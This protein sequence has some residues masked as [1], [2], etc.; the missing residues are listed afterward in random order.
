MNHYHSQRT[1][2]WLRFV[3]L[4]LA[5]LLQ[6][7]SANSEPLEATAETSADL[8]K[9]QPTPRGRVPRTEMVPMRDGALLAT[10]I[11]LPEGQPP[12]PVM[13]IRTPYGRA[14]S[15]DIA[16]DYSAIDLAVVVQDM[17]GRGESTGRDS[18]YRADGDGVLQD[19]YDTF[20]WIREQP[21]AHGAIATFGGS[22]LGIVQY[23]QSTSQPPGLAF[24]HA[25]A[26]TANLYDDIY[27]PGGVFRQKLAVQ[28]LEDQGILWFLEDIKA[29]PY[30][31]DF[32]ALVQAGDHWNRLAAPGLHIGGWFDI[33]TQGT[34]DAFLGYQHQGGEG[35]RG[36]QK[37]IMGP[38]TH[39]A[40]HKQ[41]QG[42]LSFPANAR[43]APYPVGEALN[44]L[45]EHTLKMRWSSIPDHPAS[46][47]PVQYYVMGD[48]DDPQAPGNHWRTAADWPPA[49]ARARFYLHPGGALSEDCPRQRKSHSTWI[50]DPANPVKTLCG[51]NL[52]LPEGP[53]DHRPNEARED[54]LTFTSAPLT[55]PL[56]ITG[57][58]KA[59]L[60]VSIDQPDTDVMVWLSDVYPDGRSM[61]ITDGAARLAARGT[62]SGI[63]PL[64]AHEVVDVE[65]DM[66]ST[67]I[68]L[69]TGHRLRIAL[70]SSNSPRFLANRNN[71]LPFGEMQQGPS[72]PVQVTLHHQASRTSHI[73]IP[74]PQRA[75]GDV[76][77]CPE[78]IPS[79][80]SAWLWLLGLSLLV[81]TALLLG[82]R[83][84][85]A[86]IG[87][88]SSP[89]VSALL[90]LAVLASGCR[91]TS[92]DDDDDS[93][94]TYET[95]TAPD[96]DDSA[97]EKQ[98]PLEGF[99]DIYGE[100]DV[101]DAK[102]L[103]SSAPFFH[104]NVLDLH[105]KVF[106][107]SLL[108]EG[109]QQVLSDGNLG[110]NS[111]H[112]EAFAYELL[113]RCELAHL[114]KTEAEI[115]Y[116]EDSGKK[117]DLL[118]EIEGV[119]LGVS[120]TRAF[121]WPADAP[122]TVAQATNLLEDKL[123]DVLLSSANVSPDDQ[124]T[125]QILSVIS[126]GP[127]HTQSIESAW[128]SIDSSLRADTVVMVTTTEGND[129]YLY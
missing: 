114:L 6:A 120:V 28:W 65:V 100:C 79:V 96:D 10:D 36:R 108:S 46:I 19:G 129:S 40:F 78:P 50:Y 75:Q 53:C 119:R 97:A 99:G 24:L 56:E 5:I 93:A 51:S 37:L 55:E 21:W 43:N 33:F 64:Q 60:H 8:A 2:P 106:D 11:Y 122:Y 109:G 85:R 67:S 102:G 58:I 49:A 4:T 107:E 112:S 16:L 83:R 74:L 66:L 87:R 77:T 35:A 86:R 30:R 82:K 110:G 25:S 124:W 128:A 47:P 103:Q 34:I 12:W 42:E 80:K 63:T 61:L 98:L 27:F 3:R 69:N 90:A 48:V 20:A 59:K 95:P 41:Q 115:D 92:H 26:A 117:T 116:I 15:S 68:V 123:G 88:R 121:A 71:G 57:R 84:M 73:E 18:V 1:S 22:A 62:N 113:Y 45:L 76:P 118:V 127:K 72:L 81:A 89:S 105:E 9:Q 32:W 104:S 14:D 29:H 111:L 17:R 38:W 126:Y 125:R 23:I 13:L 44:T 7:S 54:V 52:Y 101:L 94:D 70:S 31:D 39:A 91:A